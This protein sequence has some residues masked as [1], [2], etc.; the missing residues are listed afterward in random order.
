MARL[1]LPYVCSFYDARGKLRHTFRRKGH[2]RVTIKGKPGDAE[3]MAAYH[4]LLETTCTAP[5]IGMSRAQAGSVDD[6]VA[7]F[8]KHE[9]FTTGLS[10]A[11]QD[12]WRPVLHKFRDHKTP[13][14][15]TY[16]EN[17]IATITRA[18]IMAFI[19]GKTQNA[20]KN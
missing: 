14:G 3:F 17:K 15:R 2:P 6:I 8:L 5:M 11:T 19:D 18:A 13:S 1:N 9:D 20:K 12:K 10:K 16:G 4:A 7:R